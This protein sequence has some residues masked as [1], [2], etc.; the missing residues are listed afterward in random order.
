M[1]KTH[2]KIF[3]LVLITIGSIVVAIGIGSV[4]IPPYQVIQILLHKIGWLSLPQGIPETYPALV[5]D[6]RL[7]RVF[8]AFLIGAGTA[9]NG[10]VIQSV[11]KNPLASPY[12]VG[13]S[14][15]AGVGA[16][17][18]MTLGMVTG[19]V[20]PMIGVVFGIGAVVVVLA[21]S[22]AIDRNL[23][24]ITVV[25]TGMVFSLFLNAIMTFLATLSPKNAQK[26]SLWQ[27]G[28]FASKPWEYVWIFLVVLLVC[29]TI[30]L[31]YSNQLDLFT[32]GEEQAATLGVNLK[33]TKWVLLVTMA[34][35]TGTAVAFA[36]IIGFI[37]LISPH[38]V[39]KLFGSSHRIGIPANIL[40]GGTFMVLC[41]LLGRTLLSP[42]EIPIGAITAFLGAPFFVYIFL[43]ERRKTPC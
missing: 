17:L 27:M 10:A 13:V 14:A 32:F 36:G 4:T 33:T 21:V 37:D 7:P 9:V 3:L 28:S 23:S 43:W 34:T 25:L 39:R 19:A 22:V 30:F 2:Y 8:L 38:I 16:A 35:L 40:F 12:G 31:Y 41:D 18:A 29:S 5:G 11:L 42:R 1:R 24:N 20:L 6:I 26:I 15:G